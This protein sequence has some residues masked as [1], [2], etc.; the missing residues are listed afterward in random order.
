VL[1]TACESLSVTNCGSSVLMMVKDSLLQSVQRRALTSAGFAFSMLLMV[2]MTLFRLRFPPA[3]LDSM[4][5]SV[6]VTQR[7]CV[8]LLRK[9]KKP[10]G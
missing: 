9:G 2:V 8:L 5:L 1:E 7:C 10:V 4:L 3:N 6:S